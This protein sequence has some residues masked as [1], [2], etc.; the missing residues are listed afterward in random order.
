MPAPIEQNRAT[1]GQ[2]AFDVVREN[3]GDCR[4]I[5]ERVVIPVREQLIALSNQADAEVDSV[6]VSLD[7][8]VFREIVDGIYE[9]SHAKGNFIIDTEMA[10]LLAYPAAFKSV[11]ITEHGSVYFQ[12]H[13]GVSLRFKSSELVDHPTQRLREPFDSLFFV[14]QETAHRLLSTATVQEALAQP[15]QT[16]S[17]ASGLVP[18]ELNLAEADVSIAKNGLLQICDPYRMRS[19]DLHVGH[20]VSVILHGEETRG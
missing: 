1:V 5:H 14:D 10:D 6:D 18:V 9:R 4:A 17:I 13:S 3:L 8:K 12:D 16:L 15:I 7:G 20:A 19:T 2:P 11:F